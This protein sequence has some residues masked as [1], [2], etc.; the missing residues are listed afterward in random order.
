MSKSPLDR[1]RADQQ[2]K[3]FLRDCKNG[4]YNVDV[5]KIKHEINNL[6]RSRL[7]RQLKSRT[8]KRRFKEQILETEI[9]SMSYRSRIVEMKLTCVDIL[10]ELDKYLSILKKYLKT[11]YAG[12]LKKVGGT[13]AERDA[14][15][16]NMMS[17]AIINKKDL[18]NTITYADIVIADID[19]VS[20][21]VQRM[22]NAVQVKTDRRSVM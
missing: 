16:D 22:V 14:F 9:Q 17:R 12:E 4:I 19:A 11:E 2:L 8:V 21:S 20:W 10:F 3:S 7:S 15:L 6:H 5:K 18:E 1:I 13:Q